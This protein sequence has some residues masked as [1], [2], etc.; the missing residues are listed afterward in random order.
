MNFVKKPIKVNKNMLEIKAFFYKG[1]RA[2]LGQ[3]KVFEGY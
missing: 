3:K 2:D 1:F